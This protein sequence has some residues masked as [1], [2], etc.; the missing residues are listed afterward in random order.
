MTD[1]LRAAEITAEGRTLVGIAFRWDHPSL[2]PNDPGTGPYLEE[3]VRGSVTKTLRERETFPLIKHHRVDVDPVG[4]TRFAPAD[5]GLMFE[6]PLSRTRDADETLELVR[7]GAMRSVSVRFR[8][9]LHKL[10]HSTAGAVV[11][12]TEIAL[13][14]LSLAPTG[15]GIHDGAEVLAVRS[16]Q[17]APVVELD[18]AVAARRRA[19]LARVDALLG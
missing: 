13:R 12:R 18:P 11:S 7:D 17:T 5:E 2:V 16:E 3:F 1:L 4:V 6:A 19:L 14:E 8:P 9:I 15:F 10:R